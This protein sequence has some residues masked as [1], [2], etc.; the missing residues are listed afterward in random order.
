MAARLLR[1]LASVLVPARIEVRD[2]AGRI[3]GPDDLR[4]RFGEVAIALL[5]PEA[6]CFRLL[7]DTAVLAIQLGKDPDL[8]AQHVGIEGFREIV[9]RADG[10]ATIDEREV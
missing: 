9:D 3:G 10:V 8:R 6:K 7:L 2:A 5:A 1:A 4:D